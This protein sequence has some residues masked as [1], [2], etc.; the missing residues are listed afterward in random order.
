[1][2]AIRLLRNKMLGGLCRSL[3]S[4]SQKAPVRVAVTGGSGQIAYSLL[5]RIASGS[6]LGPDQPV[7][8]QVHDLTPMQAALRGVMMELDDCAFPLL[9]GVIATDV[10]T[11][12]TQDADY[13][14]L[15]GAKPRGPG[16][17]RGDLLKQNGEIFVKVGEA[18]NTN[19]RKSVK[20][21]VVGNPVNTNCLIAMNYA[22]GLKKENFTAM[23]RL[24]H[25]RAIAQLA[26]KTNSQSTDIKRM[27][28]WG[29]HSS[30]MYPDITNTTV[31][32]QAATSLV[33]RPWVVD[34]FIPVVQNR[35][36]AIIAA[37]KLSSAASAASAAVDHM[38][39]WALGSNGEWVSMAVPS[40]LY[41]GAYGVPNGLV[42][43][44]PVVCSGGNYELVPNLDMD[45]FSREKLKKTIDE[46][47]KERQAVEGLLK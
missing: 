1:M 3:R 4:F 29:N 36:A 31:R 35:G 10:M 26:I 33:Q 24:D 5:F 37:R 21:L 6:F 16:M 15:V 13:A 2:A 38:R 42:F 39:D 28:I 17:E 40:D 9:K 45:A 30:T 12:A 18:L 27:A 46:L 25:N 8:L 34:E 11:T 47:L 41:N 22:K 44:Y 43:S 14:F 7:I 32:Q 20:V 23:T 19:A